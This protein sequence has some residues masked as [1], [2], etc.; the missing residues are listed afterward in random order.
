MACGHMPRLYVT[1][2]PEDRFGAGAA[3]AA[4]V[5]QQRWAPVRVPLPVAHT[6]LVAFEG[7]SRT[8]G[9]AGPDTAGLG[10]D[11]GNAGRSL[12]PLFQFI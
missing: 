11:M 3:P 4:V 9:G 7:E 6:E 10:H 5:R 2:T 1:A 8:W 12:R